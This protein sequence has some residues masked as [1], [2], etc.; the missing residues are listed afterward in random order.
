VIVTRAFPIVIVPDRSTFVLLRRT[1]KLTV[2]GPVPDAPDI[3]RIQLSGADAVHEQP[4]L[5][6]TEIEPIPP[7]PGMVMFAGDAVTTPC[8]KFPVIEYG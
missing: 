4:L 3:M 8:W 5:I 7:F 1:P 2:P 6:V